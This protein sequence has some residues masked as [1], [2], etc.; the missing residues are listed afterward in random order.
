MGNDAQATFAIN[1]EGNTEGA[2]AAAANALKDLRDRLDADTKALGAMQRAMKNLQAGTVVP[3]QQ[4]QQLRDA[5]ASKKDAIVAAQAQY[6]ALGGSFNRTSS[7]GKGLKGQLEAMMQ[8][9]RGMPGPLGLLVSKFEAFKV[10]VGG[11]AIAVGIVGIVAALGLL[12]A[13]T[14]AAVA[15]LARYGIA[16]ADARRSELLRLEGLTKLRSWWGFAA[17]NA[18]ELQTMIDRVSAS[19]ALG[20]DKIAGY[21]EQL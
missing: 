17:G 4:A 13:A 15:A 12:V 16:Q 5:I 8:Q 14:V 11:G 1:L 9:A 3:I 7:S 2:A 18:G 6:I 10:A 19:S 20:R 21:T